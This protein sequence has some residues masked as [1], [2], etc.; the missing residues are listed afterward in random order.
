MV[1][2]LNLTDTNVFQMLSCV[3]WSELLLFYCDSVLFL[4]EAALPSG[5][6]TNFFPLTESLPGEDCNDQK[7]DY[8]RVWSEHQGNLDPY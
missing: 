4:T 1:I 5:S 2:V 7:A 8:W 6:K 3:I